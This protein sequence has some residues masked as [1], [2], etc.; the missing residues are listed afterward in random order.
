MFCGQKS[1]SFLIYFLA[2]VVNQETWYHHN[3]KDTVLNQIINTWLLY[4]LWIGQNKRA[5]SLI[6]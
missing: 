4:S 6:F 2:G 5:K 1:G 3:E